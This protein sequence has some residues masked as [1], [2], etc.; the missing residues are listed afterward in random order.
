MISPNSEEEARFLSFESLWQVVI[1]FSDS[2]TCA[3][4]VF[5]HRAL[6]I[7]FAFLF[8]SGSVMDLHDLSK[9]PYMLEHYQQHKNK[10]SAFSVSEFFDL[11]Y[12]FKAEQHDKQEHEQHKGLP[13]KSHDC[14]GFHATLV[15]QKFQPTLISTSCFTIGYS[16]FYQSTFHSSFIRS[17]WQPPKLS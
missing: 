5:M 9:L 8:L 1:Q 10:S 11:H 2:M 14:A 13:F 12:G 3:I 15:L 7:W 6:S 16:N 17:I 4:F